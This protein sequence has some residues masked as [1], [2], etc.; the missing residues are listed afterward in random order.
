MNKKLVTAASF[1][2]GG[3]GIVL[4]GYLNANPRAFTHP[5]GDLPS[6]STA[7]LANPTADPPVSVDSANTLVVSEV[8][9]K[10][11][12]PARAKAIRAP[13]MLEPCSTW[14]DVGAKFVEPRGATGVRRVRQLCFERPR[15]VD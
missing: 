11:T 13:A 4:V 6:V 7:I 15:P 3:A 14:T 8:A 1:A 10:G 5:V 12:V 2:L 9:I